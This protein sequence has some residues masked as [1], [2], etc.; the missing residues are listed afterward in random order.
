MA[1]RRRIPAILAAIGLVVSLETLLISSTTSVQAFLT[2]STRCY[3]IADRSITSTLLNAGKQAEY[4]K[5]LELPST[6]VT[7]GR[8][9]SSYSLHADDLEGGKGRYVTE[10]RSHIHGEN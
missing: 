4:G 10:C 3:C 7:C 2:T 6:Y 8:C 5:S 9:G 1:V